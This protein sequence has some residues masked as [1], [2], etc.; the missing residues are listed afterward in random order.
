M[1]RFHVF[2]SLLFLSSLTFGCGDTISDDVI[3]VAFIGDAGSTE[4]TGLR[5]SPTGQHVRAATHEGLVALDAQGDIVPAI[6]ER[7]IVTDDGASYIFRLRDSEWPGG[8][9]IEAEDVRNQLRGLV[10][11]LSGTSLGLDLAQIDQIR[12]MTGR[13]VEIRLKAPM[14][15]FLHL[16][17]QPEL[18]MAMDGQG[19]GPFSVTRQDGVLSLEAVSPSARGLPESENWQEAIRDVSLRAMSAADAV[20]AFEQGE[21]DVV[22][23]GTIIDLPL[24]NVG[25]LSRGTVRLDPALGLLGLDFRNA[26]GFLEDPLNREALA[27]AIDRTTLMQPFSIGGWV[28]STR[29]VA[30]DLPIGLDAAGERWE[31]QTIEQRRATASDR[32]ARWEAESGEDLTVRIYLPQGAGADRLFTQI[33]RDLAEVGVSARRA[34]R[35]AASDLALRD[36]LAR[37]SQPRWFLNQFNCAVISGPC[38]AEAD[39][40]VT[41]SLTV[42]DPAERAELLAEAERLMLEA[43]LFI[44]FGAPIRW[45]LVRA[46][47]TGFADNRWSMHPLFALAQRPM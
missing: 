6:A 38:S 43:N 13:V 17:A 32:V 5:L 11:R 20:R 22:L 37:F 25:A 26:E 23:N 31:G 46:G 12:A 35:P 34:D 10:A 2:L 45:S 33:A 1:R 44:P 14:P 30:S 27:M 9:R 28:P 47:V 7:W 40:L 15:D 4:E 18:G 29:I 8:K 19:T 36:R 41:Q 16:L 42:R 24:A 39:A 21:A 3:R